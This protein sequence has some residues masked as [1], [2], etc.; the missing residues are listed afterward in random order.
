MTEKQ[1]FG[2]RLCKFSL[3]GFECIILH[4]LSQDLA[5]EGK[6]IILVGDNHFKVVDGDDGI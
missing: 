4:R 2:K 6:K 1:F 5:Q 3:T